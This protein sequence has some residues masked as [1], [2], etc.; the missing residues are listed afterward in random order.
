MMVD[1]WNM[2]KLTEPLFSWKFIFAQIWV[3]RT[4]NTVFWIFWKILSLVLP[5]NNPNWKLMRLLI[6]H[7][8]FHIWQNSGQ[9][10]CWPIKF[11]SKCNISRKKWMIEVLNKFIL[12]FWVCVTRHGQSTHKIRIYLCIISRKIG[13]RGGGEIDFL[14]EECWSWEYHFWCV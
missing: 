9:K 2:S 1:N 14:L 8:Q 6:F 4:Q 12:P 5:R 11:T 13:K 3:K 7:Y 10:C